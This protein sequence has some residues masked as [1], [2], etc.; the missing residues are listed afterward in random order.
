MTQS[1]PAAPEG[2][3]AAGLRVSRRRF[4]GW[5]GAAGVAL[6]PAPPRLGVADEATA[7]PVVRATHCALSIEARAVQIGEN[8]APG[9]PNAWVYCGPGAGGGALATA[10]GPTFEQRRG[11]ACHVTYSNALVARPDGRLP[12]PP[13]TSALQAPL[14]GGVV[15][16]SDVGVVA[17]LHGGRVPGNVPGRAGESD[18]WPLAPMGCDGNPYHFPR[19]RTCIY[20]N[21]QRATLLWYHD[22]AM[23]HT[24]EHVHAGLVG[25]YFIR[26]AA[27]DALLA[28]LGGE[29]V[30]RTLVIQDRVVRADG[31]GFD[32][33]A[34]RI[35]NAP[36]ARPEFLGDRLFVNGRPAARHVL[37]PRAWRLRLLNGCNARTVA[38]ALCDLDA[39]ER[40]DGRVWWSD[41]LR[42]V[43][44]DGGLLARSLRMRPT[45]TLV[46]AP[47][48]RRDVVLDLSGLPPG[49]RRLRLVNLALRSYMASSADRPEDIYSTYAESVAA[50]SRARFTGDDAAMYRLLADTRAVVADIERTAAAPLRPPMFEHVLA[51]A[52]DDD[53]F[54][55][56][57]RRLIARP[58]V[59]FGPNRLVLLLSNTAPDDDDGKLPAPPDGA[60]WTDVQI[61]ELSKGGGDGPQWRLPFDVDLAASADPRPGRPGRGAFGYTVSRGTFFARADSPD[62]ARSGHYPAAHVPT[63]QARAGTYERW[64][65]ANI[66]NTQP[67]VH[68][69]DDLPDMHPF[70]VHLVNF[71]VTR[72]W[73]LEGG[74]F[75]A[76]APD[77]LDAVARQDTVLIP[78]D[79]LLE[80]LVFFPPGYSG[81]Y[82]YHCHILEHEDSCM[83]SSFRVT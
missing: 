46:I 25:L 65:V 8:A 61:F 38:L 70:H 17:H 18:G 53:D 82:P 73:Q 54:R 79:T 3:D 28:A 10:F 69:P 2:G 78:S 51:T 15:V 13:G 7:Q 42:L 44:A 74:R 29:D 27:D 77:P 50:P 55:W 68:D 83:M 12:L 4:L 5:S 30:E 60:E 1:N 40:G 63:I 9:A 21:R 45:E 6:L 66:G 59:Q 41:R 47:A 52:A 39:L 22:H 80:L 62:V 14:C 67:L 26:D 32:Y 48:Q 11:V 71:V 33:D 64:Y 36:H 34:G 56:N 19:T 23:D 24:G 72:R 37:A 16:Q 20:P 81:D 75:R 43:G 31:L 57:G 49:V 35:V 76:A 58:G